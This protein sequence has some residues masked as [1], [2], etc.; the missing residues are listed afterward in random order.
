MYR[1]DWFVIGVALLEACASL[2]YLYDGD[3]KQAIIWAG[4]S[5][6]NACYLLMVR[7]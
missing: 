5:I 4:P 7:G 1:G 3:W 2:T 6:S